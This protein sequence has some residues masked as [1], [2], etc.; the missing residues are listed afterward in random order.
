M[1]TSLDASS[2]MQRRRR[3][4]A[5]RDIETWS[6]ESRDCDERHFALFG[7]MIPTC[8]HRDD[9]VI[10]WEAWLRRDDGRE[11][12]RFL[13]FASQ[14]DLNVGPRR[15]AF[16]DRT[17]VLVR[18]TA[19]QLARSLDVLNDLAEVRQAK[20][21]AALFIDAS[22]NEQEAWIEAL[23]SRTMPPAP[24]AP[25]RVHTGYRCDSRASVARA[26]HRT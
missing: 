6:R 21:S 19:D 10:W 8:T 20:E 14:V 22:P 26:A 11:L 9:C 15:L 5:S 7:L 16:D 17:V 1:V 18:G 4:K 3:R 23:E 24:D 13:D 2:S 25:R 12:E